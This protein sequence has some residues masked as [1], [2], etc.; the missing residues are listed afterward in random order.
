M[1]KR[2]S[3]GPGSRGAVIKA[4]SAVI[5]TAHCRTAFR[6]L[7][8]TE[9]KVLGSDCA[10]EE[11]RGVHSPR[12]KKATLL[13][14]PHWPNCLWCRALI[15]WVLHCL[16][17][18]ACIWECKVQWGAVDIQL[19]GFWWKTAAVVMVE[20]FNVVLLAKTKVCTVQSLVHCVAV[21]WCANV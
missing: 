10:A 20:H 8:W 9:W 12:S 2:R 6:T 7:A 19:N 15:F 5:F 11:K 21:V 3:E 13:H 16:P 14:W 18:T 1:W 4:D 17:A